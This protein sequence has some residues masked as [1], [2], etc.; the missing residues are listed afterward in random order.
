MTISTNRLSGWYHRVVGNEELRSFNISKNQVCEYKIVNM[1]SYLVSCSAPTLYINFKRT[2]LKMLA[3]Y[4]CP[5]QLS[6]WHNKETL[7][8]FYNRTGLT[9][10]SMFL[11]VVL[12]K[13]SAPRIPTPIEK[14]TPDKA[15][16]ASSHVA[17]R[18]WYFPRHVL[19]ELSSRQRYH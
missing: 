17:P 10:T 15:S 14:D 5:Y 9:V 6:W 7:F 11:V 1:I 12:R 2:R 18:C 4:L 19:L 8:R 3:Q 16:P 13:R